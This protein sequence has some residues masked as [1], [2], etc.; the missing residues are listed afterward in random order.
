VP[1][2][3]PACQTTAH[4]GIAANLSFFFFRILFAKNLKYVLRQS[5]LYSGVIPEI[6]ALQPVIYNRD[7]IVVRP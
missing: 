6:S 5:P 3:K 4:Y 7:Q 2:P 1:L